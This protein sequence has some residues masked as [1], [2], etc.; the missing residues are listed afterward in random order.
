MTSTGTAF[1][2]AVLD[3]LNC[4]ASSPGGTVR[5]ETLHSFV[6]RQVR[7]WI[8]DNKQKMVNPATQV[9]MEG[10][11]RNMPLSECWRTPTSRLRASADG[12]TVTVYGTDT[13]PLWS[14]EF[15]E[16]VIHAEAADLDADAFY[17]IVVGLPSRII[18]F[19]RDKQER[20][21]RSGESMTLATF[22]TGDL[23]EKRTNQI[24]AVW[25]DASG[26]ASRLTVL[27]AE[28]QERARRDHAGLL[29]H[30]AIGRPTNMHAPRIAA[31]T[32]DSVLLL[33]AKKLSPYWQKR[34]RTS[35]EA[36]GDL[37]ILDADRN[38]R[39]D[40]AV[41][42]D[43]GTTWF[44]FEGRIVRQ[45]AKMAWQDAQVRTARARPAP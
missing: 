24:V 22:T 45:S 15:G 14:R 18:V 9:S 25:Q 27:D 30:V 34:F 38:S 28:G 20:W 2:K 42:S 26:S 23:Y 40:L 3:G 6:D 37:R 35:G 11:T 8:R 12:S 7:R 10:E 32:D 21:S 43:S 5:A 44:T 13:R 1:T 16:P 31:P 4:K 17:E 36:I 33:H 39:L 19:D 41:D 29:R